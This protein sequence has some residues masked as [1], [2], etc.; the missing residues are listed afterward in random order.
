MWI[1]AN[2]L[3]F[4]CPSFS[5]GQVYKN[6]SF[7]IKGLIILRIKRINAGQAFTSLSPWPTSGQ[8]PHAKLLFWINWFYFWLCSVFVAACKP[9]LVAVSGDHSLVVMCRLLAVVV[10]PAVEHGLHTPA[11]VVVAHGFSCPTAWGIF[12]DQG[13]NRSPCIGRR[14]LNH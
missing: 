6:N 5:L 10:S 7:Y 3:V 4:L 8:Q 1:W 9:S 14:I 13:L 12:P 11:S 2:Y